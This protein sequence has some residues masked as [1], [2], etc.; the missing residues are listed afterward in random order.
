MIE[1][2]LL[3]LLHRDRNEVAGSS[4]HPRYGKQYSCKRKSGHPR[5]FGNNRTDLIG[6]NGPDG[7][8]A[9]ILILGSRASNSACPQDTT[10][11]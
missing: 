4:T 2:V 5:G 1:L 3:P 9:L 10:T 7:N 8:P 11:A 6:L